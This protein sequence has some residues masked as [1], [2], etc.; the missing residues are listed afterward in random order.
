MEFLLLVRQGN[1]TLSSFAQNLPCAGSRYLFPLGFGL[2]LRTK[3]IYIQ[4][5]IYIHNVCIFMGDGKT[6]IH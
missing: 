5:Y 3:F 6:N 2:S 1:V 4:I